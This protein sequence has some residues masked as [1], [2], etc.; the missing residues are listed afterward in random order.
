MQAPLTY[1][2][3]KINIETSFNFAPYHQIFQQLLEPTHLTIQSQ[4]ITILLIR[5]E[6]WFSN[7]DKLLQKAEAVADELIAAINSCLQKISAS[8]IICFCKPSPSAHQQIKVLTF[9]E[10][11]ENK[12]VHFFHHHKKIH[13]IKSRQFI[14][15][16]QSKNILIVTLCKS[17]MFLTQQNISVR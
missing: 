7:A 9:L 6:D 13:V 4:D 14:F 10:S 8:M 5:W 1:L 17:H 2:L 16:I 11:L 3:N 12:V 15:I